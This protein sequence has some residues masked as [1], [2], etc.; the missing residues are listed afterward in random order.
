MGDLTGVTHVDFLRIGDPLAGMRGLDG[1]PWER[2]R[3]VAVLVSFDDRRTASLGHGVRDLAERLMAYGYQVWIS[4]WHSPPEGGA[5]PGWQCLVTYVGTAVTVGASGRLIAFLD[6][7]PADVMGEALT[8][9]LRS[10]AF[11]RTNQRA[12]GPPREI[13]PERGGARDADLGGVQVAGARRRVG[14]ERL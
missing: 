1:F 3:P 14:P 7:V 4:N 12:S 6:P 10:T 5:G 13:D 2:L 11:T 9:T 8:D